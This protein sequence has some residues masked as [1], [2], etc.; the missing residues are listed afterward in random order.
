MEGGVRTSTMQKLQEIR[1]CIGP[2]A[3]CCRDN[4]EQFGS[5]PDLQRVILARRPGGND[6]H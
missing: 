5:M 2:L 4:D 6:V 3:L 1:H